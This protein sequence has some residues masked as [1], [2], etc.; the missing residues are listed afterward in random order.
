MFSTEAS[1]KESKQEKIH[2]HD[3][4][5]EALAAIIDFI[6]TS[7]IEITEENVYLLMEAANLLQISALRVCIMIPFFV[8]DL[9]EYY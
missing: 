3:I 4:D 7:V 2:L 5:H 1:F 9:Q 6:Y 8:L